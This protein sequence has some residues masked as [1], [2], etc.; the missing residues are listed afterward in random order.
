MAKSPEIIKQRYK[1]ALQAGSCT[2]R[3]DKNIESQVEEYWKKYDVIYQT[4]QIVK[5]ELM[6]QGIPGFQFIPYANFARR[7]A[8]ILQ[9]YSDKTLEKTAERILTEHA[10]DGLRPDVLF[11]IYDRVSHLIK[12]M[13]LSP[14]G[15]GTGSR[16]GP[17]LVSD[18]EATAVRHGKDSNLVAKGGEE[19]VKPAQTN[20]Q[21]DIKDQSGPNQGNT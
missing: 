10:A 3:F 13:K 16:S 21:M 12:E 1:R 18:P 2:K 11:A 4:N 19:N 6:K 14:A 15:N 5:E 20:C 8:K 7:M 9:R 17:N